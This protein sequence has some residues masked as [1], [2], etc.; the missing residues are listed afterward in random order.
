MPPTKGGGGTSERGQSRDNEIKTRQQ[1][2]TNDTQLI[3]NSLSSSTSQ[4]KFFISPLIIEGVKLNKLELNDML[5]QYVKDIKISD[6]QLAR[7]GNFT[8]YASDVISFNRL[9]NDFT[10]IL[11][12][13]GQT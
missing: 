13:N 4:S 10:K 12:D 1:H 9:L 8:L 3:K 2:T 11:V 5:K 7:N 6:I